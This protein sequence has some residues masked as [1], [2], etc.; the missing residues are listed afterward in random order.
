MTNI[1]IIN[2]D[3][4]DY[5]LVFLDPKTQL[6]WTSGKLNTNMTEGQF[7]EAVKGFYSSVHDAWIRVT[8]VM[9]LEDGVTVTTNVLESKQTIYTIYVQRSLAN[10]ST[11]KITAT[12]I[13]TTSLITPLIPSKV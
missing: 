10:P 2:P 3:G 5:T 7:T 13:S 11:T 9:Y 12:R 8:R 4:G 1:T 6:T